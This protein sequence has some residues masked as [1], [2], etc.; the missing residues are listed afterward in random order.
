MDGCSFYLYHEYV[1]VP[2]VTDRGWGTRIAK[3]RLP[4]YA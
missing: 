1:S 2:G 4:N 3:F